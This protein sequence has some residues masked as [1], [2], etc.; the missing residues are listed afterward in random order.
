MRRI[1][2]ESRRWFM[3]CAHCGFEISVWEYGGMRYRALG[4]V[5]RLARCRNCNRIG[6]FKVYQKR[7]GSD[8]PVGP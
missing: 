2:T 8:E 3:R 6:M 1:E 7:D 4:T 5:Y